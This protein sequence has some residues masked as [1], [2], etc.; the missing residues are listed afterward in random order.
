[1]SDDK[2]GLWENITVRQ[3]SGVLPWGAN[4]LQT[5]SQAGTVFYKRQV[6]THAFLKPKSTFGAIDLP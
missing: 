1:M 5:H 4:G 3:V 6:G 2:N